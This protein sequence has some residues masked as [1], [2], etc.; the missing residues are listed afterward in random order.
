MASTMACEIPRVVRGTRLGCS[1]AISSAPGP[2]RASPSHREA[3]RSPGGGALKRTVAERRSASYVALVR[4]R[5]VLIVGVLLLAAMPAS[6]EALRKAT[7]GE[8]VG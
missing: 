6:A 8:R 2:T 3:A 4:G 5:A 1:T 7:S